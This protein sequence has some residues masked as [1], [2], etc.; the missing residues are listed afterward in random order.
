MLHVFV[1]VIARDFAKQRPAPTWGFRVPVDSDFVV[2]IWSLLDEHLLTDT[3][4][5]F[6]AGGLF[7]G[8]R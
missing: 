4:L 1:A 7:F 3:E 5:R 6:M 2:K 8:L